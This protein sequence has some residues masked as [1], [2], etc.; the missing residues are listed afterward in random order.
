MSADLVR[1]AL[2]FASAPRDAITDD[3]LAE[4]YAPDVVIDMAGRVFNPK[5]YR[6]YD[7]LRE[8]REDLYE[9][10]DEVVFEAEEFIEEG[11][12]VAAISRMRGRGRGS[13]IPIDERAAGIW[14]IRAGRIVHSRFLGAM[15]RDEALAELR[16]QSGM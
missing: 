2:A 11:D 9:T 15:S 5:T 8:Y 12:R 4:V 14:T 3:A 6:G 13:G 16:A 10:W 7:G 1:R